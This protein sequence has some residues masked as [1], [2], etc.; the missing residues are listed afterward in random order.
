MIAKFFKKLLEKLFKKFLNKILNKKNIVIIFR[1]GSA[2]G[3]HVYM[4]SVLRE[5]SEKKIKI[6]LFSNYYKLFENNKRIH[7]L[8]KFSSKSYIW[9]FLNIFKGSNILEFRSQN[10][11]KGNKHF[12]FYHK[13]QHIH[14]SQAMSEHFNL[15]LR[16]SYVE[17][18]F[19]FSKD[20]LINFQNKFKLPDEFALIQSSTKKTYTSNKD[21]SE[22]GMQAIINHFSNL[23]WIQIGKNDEPKLLNCDHLLNLDLRELAYIIYRSKFIVSYEGLFNHLASC[24]EKKIFI[25]HT[26]F[27]PIDAFKYK[28]TIIIENNKDYPCYPC[29]DIDCKDHKQLTKKNIKLEKV[30]E[31]MENRI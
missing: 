20:E 4:S 15:N 14:L 9:S 23:H 1:N 5:I 6:I 26:G 21:W 12:L 13:N 27:L 29:F 3:D 10:D 22:T 31:E 28:N 2:I 30:I 19:Y 7:K 11:K 18:E 24:F 16:Y 25:I 8:F 17:N